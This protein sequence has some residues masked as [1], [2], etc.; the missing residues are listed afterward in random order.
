M[1]RE[2]FLEESKAW[3]EKAFLAEGTAESKAQS[4]RK[5]GTLWDLEHSKCWRGMA[6]EAALGAGP[7][8]AQ[9]AR[10]IIDFI[11]KC[12]EPLRILSRREIWTGGMEG[13]P[14][15]LRDQHGHSRKEGRVCELGHGHGEGSR[16]GDTGE[17]MKNGTGH[18]WLADGRSREE[19]S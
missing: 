16:E 13:Q 8:R 17:L 7:Y 5:Q 3:Q 9:N 2:C 1:L 14:E 10:M 11:H 15:R 12:G 19:W 6:A 18:V 4:V